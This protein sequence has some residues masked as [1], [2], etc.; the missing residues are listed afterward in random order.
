MY[1]FKVNGEN[2]LSFTIDATPFDS[3]IEEK[4]VLKMSSKVG[5]DTFILNY[6]GETY[7][8]KNSSV[9]KKNIIKELLNKN[10]H[11]FEN[12]GDVLEGIVNEDGE[13]ISPEMLF[14]S[15]K[16]EKKRKQSF[17]Y[18]NQVLSEQN[19]PPIFDED[20]LK[21]QKLAEYLHIYYRINNNIYHICVN[22]YDNS[23]TAY[24]I[25]GKLI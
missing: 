21:K 9:I 6:D 3:L 22:E 14:I 17:Q 20:I 16:V 15:P 24:E 12:N 2:L 7:P 19:L 23:L 5:I 1:Y 8:V 13:S 10:W 11:L 25:F 4:L 18:L